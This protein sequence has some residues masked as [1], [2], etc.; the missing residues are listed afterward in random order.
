M[1]WAR[2]SGVRPSLRRAAHE[3]VTRSSASQRPRPPPG[4]TRSAVVAVVVLEPRRSIARG[5]EDAL[6]A[7]LAQPHPLI[8]VDLRRRI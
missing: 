3:L 8:E 1:R 2:R 7:G 6:L 4:Y 5:I